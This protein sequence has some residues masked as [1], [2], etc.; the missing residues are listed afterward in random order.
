VYYPVCRAKGLKVAIY[1]S[2]RRNKEDIKDLVRRAGLVSFGVTLPDL[3]IDQ[4]LSKKL[5]FR[6]AAKAYMSCLYCSP[7]GKNL[8]LRVDYYR[9]LRQEMSGTRE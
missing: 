3:Y 2:Q 5:R 1:S 9:R 6:E 8:T 7:F 4:I